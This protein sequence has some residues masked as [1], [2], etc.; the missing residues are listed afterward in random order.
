MLEFHF[1]AGVSRVDSGC[2]AESSSKGPGT[3]EQM[4][5][6]PDYSRMIARHIDR[7]LS[8]FSHEKVDRVLQMSQL[9]LGEGG[10]VSSTGDPVSAEASS[11][12]KEALRQ[13]FGE[14]VF[15][16]ARVNFIQN[17]CR[18]KHCRSGV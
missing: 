3:T 8:I 16:M 1:D 6:S 14:G 12:Y 11:R 7:L 15:A 5:E 18:C 2:V 4:T 9:S 17:G 10:V 13:V